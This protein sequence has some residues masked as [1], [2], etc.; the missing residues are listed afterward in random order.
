MA[1]I[2]NE[3]LDGGV[4]YRIMDQSYLAKQLPYLQERAPV[5]LTSVSDSIVMIN[6]I[7]III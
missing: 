7:I 1:T 6:P 4:S 2:E 3:P 5:L